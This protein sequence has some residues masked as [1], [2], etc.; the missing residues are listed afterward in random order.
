MNKMTAIVALM[1]VFTLAVCFI[2]LGSIS[3]ELMAALGINAGQFGT[4]VMAFYL[5]SCI[6]QL[7]IGPLVDKLGHKP[8]AIIG[9]VVTSLSMFILSFSST[10]YIALIACIIMGVG[11]MS[12]NTMGNT[13]IPVVLFEGKDMVRASNFGNGFFG[14]G[15][16]LTPLLIVFILKTL[17]LDYSAALIT[18]GILS[19]IFLVFALIAKFPQVSTGFK[20]SLAFK[21]LLKPAVLVAALAM[22]CYTSL[23][24]SMG[25]WIKKL[26]EEL[27]GGSVNIHA[28][29]KAGLVLSLFGVAM[30]VGRFLAASVK[31]L[32]A[33]GSKVIVFASVFSLLAILIMILAKKPAISIVAVLFVGLAFAP[34]FPTIVGVTFAKFNP[35]LYGSIFGI[36]FAVGL[37]GGTF[38]PKFIG[39]LSVGSSVQQSLSIAA[40][41]AVVLLMISMFIG[42]IGKPK[43]DNSITTDKH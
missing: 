40:I 41:I 3:V 20:F 39:N 43:T 35:G 36:I 33:R 38:V 31:N 6:V 1:A 14:L 26:M 2:V 11:A 4:L 9:F 37:L 8:V 28:A 18:I 24:A 5:T 10:F 29:M 27:Y 21:L 15:Y 34:I 16:V 42:R 12:L 30:M 17:H 32:T 7:F 13:L 25:T 19:F 23:E 22:F